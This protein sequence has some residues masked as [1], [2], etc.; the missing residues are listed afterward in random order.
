MRLLNLVGFSCEPNADKIRM[1]I[2]LRLKQMLK[3]VKTGLYTL[4]WV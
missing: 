1:L 2:L 3:Q 4:F